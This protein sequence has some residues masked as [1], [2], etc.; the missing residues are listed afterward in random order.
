MAVIRKKNNTFGF[1]RSLGDF[2]IKSGNTSKS[3]RQILDDEEKSFSFFYDEDIY[4]KEGALQ[5]DNDFIS[6]NDDNTIIFENKS[7]IPEYGIELKYFDVAVETLSNKLE[8]TPNRLATNYQ[9]IL[10]PA[11]REVYNKTLVPNYL[12]ENSKE[13]LFYKETPITEIISGNKN[14]IVFNFDLYT[15]CKLSFNKTSSNNETITF[16]TLSG[17]KTFKKHN[18]NIAY[19]YGSELEKIE[20]NGWAS[21]DYLENIAALY[22]NNISSFVTAPIAFNGPSLPQAPTMISS[23]LSMPI[24]TFFFP[25]ASKFKAEKRHFIDISKYIKKSFVIEKINI[26]A[27]VSNYS[28]NKT[29]GQI[30][31]NFLNFFVLNQ[32]GSLGDTARYEQAREVNYAVSAFSADSSSFQTLSSVP[33]LSSQP[34][35]TSAGATD[36]A[37]GAVIDNESSLSSQEFVIDN[38]NNTNTFNE[39]RSQLNSVRELITYATLAN[40]SA[41]SSDLDNLGNVIESLSQNSDFLINNSNVGIIDSSNHAEC[42]YENRIVEME[43]TPRIVNATKNLPHISNYAIFPEKTDNSSNSLGSRSNKFLDSSE[44]ASDLGNFIIDTSVSQLAGRAIGLNENVYKETKYVIEPGDKIIV[45][46]SLSPSYYI[47]TTGTDLRGLDVLELID[48]VEVSFSGYYLENN[49]KKYYNTQRRNFKR[50]KR[51]GDVYNKVTDSLGSPNKMMQQGVYVDNYHQ[52]DS[53]DLHN[54]ALAGSNILNAATQRYTLNSSVI[55]LPNDYTSQINNNVSKVSNNYFIYNDSDKRYPFHYFDLRNFGQFSNFIKYFK[56]APYFNS[57]TNKIEHA[58]NKN[59]KR[60]FFI[61]KTPATVYA[62]IE[63]DFSSLESYNKTDGNWLRDNFFNQINIKY[64]PSIFND[65]DM[66][67]YGQINVAGFTVTDY[68]NNKANILIRDVEPLPVGGSKRFLRALPGFDSYYFQ[69]RQKNFNIADGEDFLILDIESYITDSFTFDAEGR[70]QDNI[71]IDELINKIANLLNTIDNNNF[72][73]YDLD[74]LSNIGSGYSHARLSL[75]P[76][77]VG[78]YDNQFI[79]LEDVQGN[80]IKFKFSINDDVYTSES[81]SLVFDSSDNTNE[82]IIVG[83]RQIS[84]VPSLASKEQQ[85]ISLKKAIELSI[86]KIDTFL[87]YNIID[88]LFIQQKIIGL[89]GD[90]TI[91]KFVAGHSSFAISASFENGGNSTDKKFKLEVEA[92]VLETTEQYKR[93]IRLKSKNA[94]KIDNLSL[95]SGTID[96]ANFVNFYVSEGDLVNSYNIDNNARYNTEEIS[97]EES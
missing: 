62:D 63:F 44:V 26:R 67:D 45:G 39:E 71:E 97:F 54:V 19:L 72:K 53:D 57:E 24:D 28:V 55:K 29:S 87:P 36:F 7:V 81:S 32:R 6:F 52:D 41:N 16:Q 96:Q 15:S 77:D 91:T 69:L 11:K 40:F 22:R 12:E 50:N 31:L 30:A 95:N 34:K 78:F 20:E 21:F 25:Y 88:Q 59:L 89:D 3:V 5:G 68:K 80:E 13:N 76:D 1:S 27:K 47:D 66:I 9:T 64:R 42:I 35:Y 33:D 14:T 49:K 8:F 2:V 51:F 60:G 75:D 58:L 86:L 94:G 48:N 18:G 73:S 70:R 17:N 74:P 43:V 90:T 83:I 4:S 92:E 61:N 85:I 79:T 37:F 10:S 56:N 23:T 84:E 93:T 82:T 38:L 65:I 46:V